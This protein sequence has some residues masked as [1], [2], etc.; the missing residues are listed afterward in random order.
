MKRRLL[1]ESHSEF[2]DTDE[3]NRFILQMNDEEQ[4]SMSIRDI[5]AEILGT[6]SENIKKIS[7]S[8]SG[9][10]VQTAGD[11][12]DTGEWEEEETTDNDIT[13]VESFAEFL[14]AIANGELPLTIYFGN[15][16]KGG[17]QV[18]IK[19]GNNGPI[20]MARGYD[21]IGMNDIKQ[22][23]IYQYG[24]GWQGALSIYQGTIGFYAVPSK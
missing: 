13:D 24:S 15:P 2:I 6:K 8:G 10:K 12:D 1:K 17:V 11:T 19:E 18:A 14:Y 22:I 16:K 3:V 7:P 4:D 23:D 9:W 20:L 5:I 21:P